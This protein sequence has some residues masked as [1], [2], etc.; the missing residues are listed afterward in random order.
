MCRV[1]TVN[2]EREILSGAK[3]YMRDNFH[4]YDK[5]KYFFIKKS[6]VTYNIPVEPLKFSCIRIL[7]IVNVWLFEDAFADFLQTDSNI[8]VDK[9]KVLN[10]VFPIY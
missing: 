8:F 10:S 5:I 1:Y 4:V 9:F 6:F 7:A 2:K 3:S